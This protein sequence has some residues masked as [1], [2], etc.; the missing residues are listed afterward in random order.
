MASVGHLD[1]GV[2]QP[3]KI[4]VGFVTQRVKFGG[5]NDRSRQSGKVGGAQRGDTRVRGIVAGREVVEQVV[6]QRGL[7][8]Q[9]AS[10]ELSA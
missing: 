4:F 3:F 9:E 2:F 7:A 10:C 6:L 8:D 5:V 1:P